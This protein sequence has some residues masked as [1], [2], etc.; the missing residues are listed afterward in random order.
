[1]PKR[2]FREDTSPPCGLTAGRPYCQIEISSFLSSPDGASTG[3]V[4]PP[5]TRVLWMLPPIT[6]PTRGENKRGG[7][8][9]FSP[10]WSFF[11]QGKRKCSVL[12]VDWPGE[13]TAGSNPFLLFL[14]APAGELPPRESCSLPKTFR[15][16]R[17]GSLNTLPARNT[18]FPCPSSLLGPPSSLFPP[19]FPS[20]LIMQ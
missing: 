20:I 15:Q 8:F 1:L 16:S 18:L 13:G 12:S 6:T 10:E 11:F 3:V 14:R 9:F 19:P 17:Q 2:C 4:A 7:P 5:P